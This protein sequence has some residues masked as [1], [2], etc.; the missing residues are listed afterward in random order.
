MP[1]VEKDSADY[2]RPRH[3]EHSY[4]DRSVIVDGEEIEPTPGDGNDYLDGYRYEKGT[5]DV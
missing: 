4:P 3:D 1:S 2:C 5:E